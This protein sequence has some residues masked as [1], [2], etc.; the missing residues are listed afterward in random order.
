MQC[1]FYKNLGDAMLADD[2]LQ[3]IKQLFLQSYPDPS[4]HSDKCIL[5]YHLSERR[6]HCEVT[7]YFSPACRSMAQA[8]DATPCEQP[9]SSG[10]GL[11]VGKLKTPPLS[12]G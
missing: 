8:L 7:V 11:L 4:Q 9:S 2:S 3:Q 10:L 12:D 1:W 5:Y 6:L